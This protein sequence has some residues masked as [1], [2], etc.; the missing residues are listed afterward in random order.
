MIEHQNLT[1]LYLRRINQL[2]FF[3]EYII[4]IRKMSKYLLKPDLDV[5]KKTKKKIKI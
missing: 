2:P 4:H 1:L 3:N 5:P